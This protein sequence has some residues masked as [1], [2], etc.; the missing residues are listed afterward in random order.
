VQL[1]NYNKIQN[2]LNVAIGILNL[3]YE[4]NMADET[5]IFMR[6]VVGKLGFFLQL[7]KT[8]QV[9]YFFLF[10]RISPPPSKSF[11]LPQVMSSTL[12]RV[13]DRPWP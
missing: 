3:S 1:N 4:G 8:P 7:L 10:L 11:R 2:G 13:D 5:P 9:C 12:V 6:T